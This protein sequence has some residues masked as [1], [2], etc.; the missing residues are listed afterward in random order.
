MPVIVVLLL[1][2]VCTGHAQAADTIE[3]T[4]EVFT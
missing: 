4:N 3:L 1:G 2:L